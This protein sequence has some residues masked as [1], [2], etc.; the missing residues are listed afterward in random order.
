MIRLALTLCLFTLMN[1]SIKAGGEQCF[2]I[3][4]CLNTCPWESGDLETPK[5]IYRYFIPSLNTWDGWYNT[6]NANANCGD[7]S[8]YGNHKPC[9]Q[10]Q[11]NVTNYCNCNTRY[12][13]NWGPWCDPSTIPCCDPQTGCRLTCASNKIAHPSQRGKPKAGLPRKETR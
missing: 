2:S 1:G 11:K 4:E 3:F 10:V 7:T 5:V 12:T 6:A 13:P 9:D 8:L